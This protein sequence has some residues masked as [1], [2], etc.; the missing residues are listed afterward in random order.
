MSNPHVFGKGSDLFS[1]T[2]DLLLKHFNKIASIFVLE[3][4]PLNIFIERFGVLFLQDQCLIARG[5]DRLH[6]KF[7]YIRLQINNN[8]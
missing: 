3:N 7:N 8:L 2:H 6:G 1:D 5:G 4:V